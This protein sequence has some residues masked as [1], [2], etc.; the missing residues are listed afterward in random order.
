MTID[1]DQYEDFVRPW[2]RVR[3]GRCCAAQQAHEKHIGFWVRV[4][5]DSE[6]VMVRQVA[7]A[8][9]GLADDSNV[10]TTRRSHR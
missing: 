2:K 7:A 4:A 1:P 9:A 8:D 5:V 6:I 3:M 10:L